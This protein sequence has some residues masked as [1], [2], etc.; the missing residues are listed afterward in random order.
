MSLLSLNIYTIIL[1][2]QK[3]LTSHH[4]SHFLFQKGTKK[5]C[6]MFPENKKKGEDRLSSLAL[7]VHYN[8]IINTKTDKV[9]H[10]YLTAVFSPYM[11]HL[12]L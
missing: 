6:M 8:K 10:C 7:T 3:K 11:S 4:V 5:S 12:F 9:N 1:F 2:W